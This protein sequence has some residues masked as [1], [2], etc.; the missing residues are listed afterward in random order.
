MIFAA[1]LKLYSARGIGAEVVSPTHR[2]QIS[3]RSVPSLPI[4]AMG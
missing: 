4:F 2:G 3:T 1:G